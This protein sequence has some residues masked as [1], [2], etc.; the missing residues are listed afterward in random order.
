MSDRTIDV[1]Q[2][3]ERVILNFQQ[4]LNKRYEIKPR[5]NWS[6]F[7][8]ICWI[9]RTACCFRIVIFEILRNTIVFY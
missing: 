8:T 2:S 3:A 5:N 9:R 7:G 4:E 1:Q 6:A